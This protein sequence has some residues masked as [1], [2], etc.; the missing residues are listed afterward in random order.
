MRTIKQPW[1]PFRRPSFVIRHSV[2]PPHLTHLTF[3]THL[4]VLF[5]ALPLCLPAQNVPVLQKTLA[6]GMSVLLVER[7]DEPTIA[8]GWVAHVGSSNE[9][10]GITGIARLFEHMMFKGTPAIGTKDYKQD[11]Q[12]IAA[13]ERVRDDIRQEEKKMR[14]EYRR[15]E[16]DDILKP[17]NKTPR[18]RELDKKFNDLIARQRNILVKNEFDRIYSGAGGSGMNAFTSEDMTAYV[19]PPPPTNS[20][21]G[22]GW[23]PSAFSTPSFANSMPSATSS[24]RNGAC[25]PNPLPWANLP[26]NSTPCSGNLPRTVGPPSVGLRTSRPSPRPRPT[27]STAFIIHP[28]TSPSSSSATS[29]PPTL[30]PWPK[31]TSSV[32]RAA[33]RTRPMSSP[34]KSSS[35]PKSACTPRPKPIPRWTSN[36]T[37][38]PSSTV[39]P[40]PSRSSAS[41][42]P[43]APAAFTRASSWAAP[44][45]LPWMPAKSPRNGPATSTP[46]AKPAK[47]T[48]PRKSSKASTRTSKNSSKPKSRPKNSKR[49]KTTSLPVNIASS[50]PTSPSSCTSSATTATAIGARSTPPP[51]R[52]RPSPPPTSNASPTN[53]SPPKTAPSASTPAK[54]EG[55]PSRHIRNPN[56]E[57]RMAKSEIRNPGETRG[58]NAEDQRNPD[59]L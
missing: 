31:N 4:T 33:K 10:P 30:R 9:R 32:S 17:E 8:G 20:S 39:T 45:P 11:L 16:I 46:M 38:S 7:H 24:S 43:P 49:S 22:C 13:Q 3:L 27:T 42:S 54:R 59:C 40:I 56:D 29:S 6:N 52:S 26:N 41:C 44:S 14:A 28:R 34:S 19:S 18:Y 12:I 37:P 35:P 23:S 47:A 57:I 48:N 50:P 58:P 25:A 2:R 53:I 1:V 51:P 15:G 21:S 5:A 36:G 55:N